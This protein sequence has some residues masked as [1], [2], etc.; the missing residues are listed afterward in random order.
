MSTTQYE[1]IESLLL[2]DRPEATL[3]CSTVGKYAMD[4]DTKRIRKSQ[5]GKRL[6]ALTE[7]E[8]Q[9]Y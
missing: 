4:I 2:R 9:S 3:A 5:I 6:M 8:F 7:Q 1:Q